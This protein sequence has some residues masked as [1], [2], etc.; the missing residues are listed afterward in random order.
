ML[1]LLG[2]DVFT[3]T[4]THMNIHMIYMHFIMN[5]PSFVTESLLFLAHKKTL[6]IIVITCSLRGENKYNFM[7]VSLLIL[8]KFRNL[9]ELQSLGILL[10]LE[11]NK[12]LLKSFSVVKY[13]SV[14]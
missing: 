11:E 13:F 10:Q 14:N 4:H 1:M 12:N 5:F 8:K 7:D 2:E 3:H 6:N 9:K